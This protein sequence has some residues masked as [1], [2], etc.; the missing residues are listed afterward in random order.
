MS[1]VHSCEEI[2][3]ANRVAGGSPP[4]W[5]SRHA[6]SDAAAT[7]PATALGSVRVGGSTPWLSI[8]AETK[9]RKTTRS[10]SVTKYASPARPFSA[11][12]S[13]PSTTLSTWVVSVSWVPPPIQANRPFSTSSRIPGSRVVSPAP[14]TKRGRRTTA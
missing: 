9:S 2:H 8:S 14:Q 10:P 4:R 7:G 13:R 5:K 1:I 11:A 12:S 6:V 3:T